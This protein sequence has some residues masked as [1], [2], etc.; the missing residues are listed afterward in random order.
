MLMG[1]RKKNFP[2]ALVAKTIKT[3]EIPG[4]IETPEEDKAEGSEAEAAAQDLIDAI[5]AGDAKAVVEA[6]KAL[7]LASDDEVEEEDDAEE[8][9]VVKP[10]SSAKDLVGK[11][12]A[13]LR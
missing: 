10:S 7:D 8:G 1:D 3:K 13:G 4:E 11:L 5:K 12:M 6:F 9:E 2:V